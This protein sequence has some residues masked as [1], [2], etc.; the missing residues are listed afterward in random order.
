MRGKYKERNKLKNF[1]VSLHD[2]EQQY[3]RMTDVVVNECST[4]LHQINPMETEL[5]IKL[6]FSSKEIFFVGIGRVMLSLQAVAKRFNH[7]GLSTHCV[8][9]INEPAITDQDLLV[10]GSGSGES[11]IPVAIANK[12]KTYSAKI[13]WIGSNRHSSISQIADLSIIFPTG[14]KLTHLGEIGS[15]QPMTSLFEQCL[16]LYGDIIANMIIQNKK[17]DLQNIWIR[18]ANLE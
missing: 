7:L 11:L 15:R 1:D 9:D 2:I 4:A 5:F 10:V 18:H 16:M 3:G 14:N 12:A 13:V 17:I 8:G 6:L